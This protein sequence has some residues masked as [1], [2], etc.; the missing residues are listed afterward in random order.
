MNIGNIKCP[1][2]NKSLV[3]VKLHCK[4][5]ELFIEGSFEIDTMAKLDYEDQALA[6]AFIRCFGSI[7]KLQDVLGVSYPTARGR[8]EKLVEKL[9]SGMNVNPPQASTIQ[10]LE[11]GEISVSE[12]L[13]VL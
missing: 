11:N 9:N 8:L 4:S 6:I 7:K 2:C 5:C 13:E 1:V 12:A 10:R 3:P